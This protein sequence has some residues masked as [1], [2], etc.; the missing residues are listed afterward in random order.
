MHAAAVCE[1]DARRLVFD[2]PYRNRIFYRQKANA[3]CGIP[4]SKL[5]KAGVKAVEILLV[6]AKS[7][8]SGVDSN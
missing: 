2:A 1:Y 8:S 6:W 3:K 5:T 4:P 7:G